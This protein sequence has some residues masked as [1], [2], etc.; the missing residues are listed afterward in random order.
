MGGCSLHSVSYTHLDVYKRQQTQLEK[1]TLNKAKEVKG[2]AA[3]ES[4]QGR[5]FE[6]AFGVSSFW[7]SF[8]LPYYFKTIAHKASSQ[9]M[10]S[11]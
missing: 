7:F 10:N 9:G 1:Q 4:S 6:I 5:H 2:Q 3:E 8:A 11:R